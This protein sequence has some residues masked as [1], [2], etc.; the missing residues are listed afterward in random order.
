LGGYG[1]YAF[2]FVFAA[3]SVVLGNRLPDRVWDYVA[4]EED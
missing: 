4:D 1:V 3:G 2:F